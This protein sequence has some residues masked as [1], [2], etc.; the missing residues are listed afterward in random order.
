LLNFFVNGRFKIVRQEPSKSVLS[1]KVTFL[2][3]TSSRRATF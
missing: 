1:E 2:M 3:S